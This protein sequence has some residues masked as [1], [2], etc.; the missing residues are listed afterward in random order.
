MITVD[1][2][3]DTDV[4]KVLIRISYGHIW[5]IHAAPPKCESNWPIIYFLTINILCIT[6]NFGHSFDF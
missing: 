4:P 5:H 6:A 1:F 3:V 2:E